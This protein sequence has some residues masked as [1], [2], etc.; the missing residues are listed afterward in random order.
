[1]AVS[2]GKPVRFFFQGNCLQIVPFEANKENGVKTICQW[3]E[4]P[5]NDAAAAGD[6]Q[7]D[8]GMMRLTGM[9]SDLEEPVKPSHPEKPKQY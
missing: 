2:G 3:L 5:V 4:I 9:Y 6:S 1:M 7:E 8:L